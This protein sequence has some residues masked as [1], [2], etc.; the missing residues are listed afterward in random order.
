[1]ADENQKKLQDLFE[2]FREYGLSQRAIATL[3]GLNV[4]VLNECLL[5][6][7]TTTKRTLLLIQGALRKYKNNAATLPHEQHTHIYHHY[8]LIVLILCENDTALATFVLSQDPNRRATQCKDWLRAAN[9]RRIAIYIVNTELGFVQRHIAD[10]L[11]MSPA[12]VSYALNDVEDLRE[13]DG[14]LDRKI[15][16]IASVFAAGV[17]P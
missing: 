10:T 1:M 4:Q 3:S 6:K 11:N 14:E 16:Q 8:R 13:E 7:R 5:G 12:A 2:K 9:I 15:E 17:C